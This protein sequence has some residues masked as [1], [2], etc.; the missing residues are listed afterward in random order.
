VKNS[1]GEKIVIAFTAINILL[2]GFIYYGDKQARSAVEDN[3]QS[4]QI[5][6]LSMQMQEMKDSMKELYKEVHALMGIKYAS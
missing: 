6:Y 4:E 3:S 5:K 2:S 1:L